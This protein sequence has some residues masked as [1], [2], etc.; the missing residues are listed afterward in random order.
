MKLTAG[1]ALLQELLCLLEEGGFSQL[2][3]GPGSSLGS[4]WI[5]RL[6]KFGPTSWPLTCLACSRRAPKAC[7]DG[8]LGAFI[9]RGALLS[10]LVMPPPAP[11]SDSSLSLEGSNPP[12]RGRCP[13]FALLWPG[14]DA[15]QTHSP[16]RQAPFRF[17]R[18]RRQ[19]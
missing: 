7:E 19:F 9:S 14:L 18:S 11:P 5:S 8:R 4:V 3:L 10:V 16:P 17:S 15:I 6:W 2:L 1:V 13:L 12:P